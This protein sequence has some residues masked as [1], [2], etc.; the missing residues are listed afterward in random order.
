MNVGDFLIGSIQTPRIAELETDENGRFEI[1]L[2]IG[3]YSVFTVEE[4]GYF[5]NVF[6]QYNHVNPIQVKEGEW[7]FLEIVV[8]YLAVY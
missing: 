5:A 8:N 1:E 4:E 6:D 7:T 2:P 3:A